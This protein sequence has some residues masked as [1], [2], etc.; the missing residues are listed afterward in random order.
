MKVK[1]LNWDGNTL[2]NLNQRCK[3]LYQKNILCLMLSVGRRSIIKINL[4]KESDELKR[5]ITKCRITSLTSL[6]TLQSRLTTALRNEVYESWKPN[7]Q[8]RACSVQILVLMPSMQS[9]QSSILF[10]KTASPTPSNPCNHLA[11]SAKPVCLYL[12]LNSYRGF[13]LITKCK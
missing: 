13:K 6:K 10:G 1:Q 7:R 8:C 3:L 9:T 11:T 12:W 4:R 5:G 2:R